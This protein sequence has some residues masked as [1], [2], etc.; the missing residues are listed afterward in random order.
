MKYFENNRYEGKELMLLNDSLGKFFQVLQSN[1]FFNQAREDADC[2][3]HRIKLARSAYL[4]IAVC[5]AVIARV[6]EE[7]SE[8]ALNDI[9]I[10]VKPVDVDETLASLFINLFR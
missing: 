8:R 4:V 7:E 2:K 1:L 10:E 9:V 6:P 3:E 5:E